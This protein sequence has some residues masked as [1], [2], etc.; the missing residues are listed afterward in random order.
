MEWRS[1][2]KIGIRDLG[3]AGE[4]WAINGPNC[5][6]TKLVAPDRVSQLVVSCSGWHYG[7]GLG[8]NTNLSFGRVGTNPIV[9]G[10][11]W[12]RVG[13]FRVVPRAAH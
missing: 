10:P 12:V 8:P 9:R 1:E 5:V 3:L 11:G 4:V 7:R 2:G 13:F 6:D